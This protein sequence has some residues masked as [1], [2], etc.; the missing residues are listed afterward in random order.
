[1]NVFIGITQHPENLD[2]K[3]SANSG[4]SESLMEVGPFL[5]KEDA[6]AWQDYLT[7]KLGKATELTPQREKDANE[8]WYGFTFEA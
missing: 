8:L 7:K 5:T 3:I 6:I 4:S 1:M 2:K